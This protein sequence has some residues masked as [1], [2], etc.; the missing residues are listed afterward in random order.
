MI[1][2]DL[3]GLNQQAL[4]IR[5]NGNL[6]QKSTSSKRPFFVFLPD[7]TI[8]TT[9]DVVIAIV[10]STSVFIL[11]FRIAFL[12]WR[13]PSSA[14]DCQG[15]HDE[16]KCE[17]LGCNWI[18]ATSNCQLPQL[19]YT[20]LF[21][22]TTTDFLFLT[23]VMMSFRSAYFVQKNS[24]RVLV[25]DVRKISMHYVRTWFFIDLSASIPLEFIN[26]LMQSRQSSLIGRV[27][28]SAKF[29]RL[30]NLAKMLMQDNLV[31]KLNKN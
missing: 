27:L 5:G 24:E 9:W 13:M 26:F 3:E 12:E 11:P 1:W 8:K 16:Y 21:V 30:V 28:S 2:W 7:D 6:F 31:V 23:D 18:T 15:L 25:T 20:L 22:D 17:L 14:Q 10:L 19:W 4:D 29:I